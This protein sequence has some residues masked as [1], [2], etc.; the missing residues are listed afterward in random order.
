MTNSLYCVTWFNEHKSGRPSIRLT[1]HLHHC[2]TVGS[3]LCDC[4]CC[5]C[6]CVC[7]KGV[8]AVWT[9]TFAPI[10]S[11]FHAHFSMY[12][13][14]QCTHSWDFVQW[15]LTLL[16]PHVHNAIQCLQFLYNLHEFHFIDVP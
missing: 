12:S 4:A 10:S 16:F 9:V 1:Q 3:V 11:D 7:V 5:W 8:T 15:R 6:V 2:M 13:E 14:E